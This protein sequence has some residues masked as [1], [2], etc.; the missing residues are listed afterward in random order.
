ML[1]H[2]VRPVAAVLAATSTVGCSKD[3]MVESADVVCAAGEYS[4]Q[5]RTLRICNDSRTGWIEVDVCDEGTR[6]DV[7]EKTCVAD[8]IGGTGGGGGGNSYDGQACN[9]K[10]K[11]VGTTLEVGSLPTCQSFPG[12]PPYSPHLSPI[13]LAWSKV[14]AL[15]RS[16]A[17]R[18]YD[19]LGQRPRGCLAGSQPFRHPRMVPPL[20]LPSIRLKGALAW[21][22]LRSDSAGGTR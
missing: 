5:V 8:A 11:G 13:E 22:I 10:E 21:T 18:T 19:D 14:K 20:W 2:S 6:C 12:L 1:S 9:G 17:A 3:N 7:L 15:L 16:A 4:C